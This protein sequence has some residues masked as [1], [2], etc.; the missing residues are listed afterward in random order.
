MVRVAAG[1]GEALWAPLL[2][3][4]TATAAGSRRNFIL[5]LLL[6]LLGSWLLHASLQ[7]PASAASRCLGTRSCSCPH[8]CSCSRPAGRALLIVA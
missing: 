3:P 6:L 1:Q 7:V 8:P 5:R 2:V 4:H